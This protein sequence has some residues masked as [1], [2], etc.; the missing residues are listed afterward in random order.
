[1]RNW[2]LRVGPAQDPVPGHGAQAGAQ[3]RLLAG[4]PRGT[5]SVSGIAARCGRRRAC[6]QARTRAG[7][8]RRPY[9]EHLDLAAGGVQVLGVLPIL[10]LLKRV[11]LHSERH[12]LL[13]PVLPRG[14]LCADAVHLGGKTG[15]RGAAEGGVHPAWSV[16]TQAPLP[17]V[18]SMPLG[19][20][21]LH[22]PVHKD[23]PSHLSPLT[24]EALP[25]QLSLGHCSRPA[26]PRSPLTSLGKCYRQRSGEG[27]Q[28]SPYAWHSG[29][30]GQAGR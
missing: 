16:H 28:L 10:V 8:A 12:P 11:D 15:R 20:W 24:L 1:M 17:P 23:M 6:L 19:S 18:L 30:L 14:E 5:A 27:M 29:Y 3:S 2:K 7:E 9:L 4:P 26:G 22:H 13:A 21:S 25:G